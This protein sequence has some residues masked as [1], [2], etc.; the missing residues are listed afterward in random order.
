MADHGFH[1]SSASHL[2][3]NG[4]GGMPDL[5]ADKDLERVGTVVTA[6]AL[7]AVDAADGDPCKLFEVGDDNE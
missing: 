7:V 3:A 6:I 2:A 4:V 5:A 1:G